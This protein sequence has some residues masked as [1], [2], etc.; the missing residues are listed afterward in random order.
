LLS[1]CAYG[2]TGFIPKAR[3]FG[4]ISRCSSH[5]ASIHACGSPVAYCNHKQSALSA[6]DHRS[7]ASVWAAC[8]SSYRPR[9]LAGGRD[10]HLSAP[11]Q[12]PLPTVP[13]CNVI[14]RNLSESAHKKQAT[15][16]NHKQP[17]R[18]HT[19]ALEV[20]CDPTQKRGPAEVLR[21]GLVCHSELVVE[22]LVDLLLPGVSQ[23]LTS[24]IMCSTHGFG[25]I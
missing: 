18:Q 3:I 12:Q 23:L 14:T 19:Q 4:K 21:E 25:N 10:V 8:R 20:A 5:W 22:L 17:V 7:Q 15:T 11:C 2:S 16:D 6:K 24:S 13:R 1:L 9:G